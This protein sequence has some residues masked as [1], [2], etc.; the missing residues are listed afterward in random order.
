MAS[1]KVEKCKSVH[2][3]RRYTRY[4]FEIVVT[5]RARGWKSQCAEIRIKNFFWWS[6]YSCLALVICKL[7]G[8][9][10]DFHFCYGSSV[11]NTTRKDAFTHR[12]TKSRQCETQSTK[13]AEDEQPVIQSTRA[14]PSVVSILT[15][16][17]SRSRSGGLISWDIYCAF[18]CILL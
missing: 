2:K 16:R 6:V 11:P 15:I 13:G 12:M 17:H 7:T 1:K 18:P 9:P 14:L 5:H 8:T 4:F 3:E 10:P